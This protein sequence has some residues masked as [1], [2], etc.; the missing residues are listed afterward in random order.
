VRKLLADQPALVGT[1]VSAFVGLALALGV[2]PTLGAAVGSILTVAA[3][4]WI[5]ANVYVPATVTKLVGDAATSVALQLTAQTAGMAGTI[6]TGAQAIVDGVVT[7][8]V[9]PKT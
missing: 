8:A 3:G 2:D 4:L 5:R 7:G 9:G 1:L 6:G